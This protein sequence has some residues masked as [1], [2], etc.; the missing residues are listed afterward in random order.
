MEWYENIKPTTIYSDINTLLEHNK[1]LYSEEAIIFLI[2]SNSGFGSQL[3]II[4]QNSLY[5]KK[6]NPK[7]HC[8][9][10][11]SI[12]HSSFKYH[13]ISYNNSFFLYFK[14]VNNINENIKYYFV[15]LNV[16]EY[17]FI[18]PQFING[19]NVD[20]IQI[21]K[22]YSD[23]FKQNF[24]VKKSD[25]IIN[26]INSIKET[27]QMPLIG[28]HI[29]SYAQ[30]CV[31]SDLFQNNNGIEMRIINIKKEL[32]TKYNKYNIFLATDV[33]DY[34]V[35]FKNI[36]KES[37]VNIYYNEYISRINDDGNGT[38]GCFNGYKDSIMNLNEYTGLKLGNDII[39]ECISLI[40]CDFYYVSVT[41]IAFI[42]SFFN[43]KMN[44]I[45]FN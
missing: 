15:N 23:Y 7:L 4:V 36:F 35:K 37:N 6:L 29:R 19:L 2:N 22:E 38:N 25:K 28:I 30:L 10:H 20:N 11:F 16:I 45:H 44:G 24:E 32:D 42:T 31:H 40:N 39:D 9:G 14:Y 21:N 41:N 26:H 5:L 18:V 33:S 27:T 12:N 43:D 3:T 1:N 34:I 13:E 8:L 17:P